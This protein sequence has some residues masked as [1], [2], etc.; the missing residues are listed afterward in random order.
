M[1]TVM[2]KCGHAAN[3]K[4]QIDGK[5]VP[6]CAICSGTKE[7]AHIVDDTPPD[8]T[9]RKANCSY[10][11]HAIVDSSP[12]LAFFEHR[13]DRETDIYYCGCYGFN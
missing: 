4:T 1:S 3:A 11:K 2:M 8:L 7:G 10:G 5:W 9:G 13:A 6:S 12:D